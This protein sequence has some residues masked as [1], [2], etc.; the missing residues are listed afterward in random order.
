M[1][2]SLAPTKP[3][4]CSSWTLSLE[5]GWV[6]GAN[7]VHRLLFPFMCVCVFFRTFFMQIIYWICVVHSWI[8]VHSCWQTHEWRRKGRKV[9]K[10]FLL[11]WDIYIC[12]QTEI[13]SL[14]LHHCKYF[15]FHGFVVHSRTCQPFMRC[16]WEGLP[17]L[18]PD[19]TTSKSQ[20]CEDTER[21]G[22]FLS[23]TRTS[24]ITLHTFRVCI[25]QTPHLI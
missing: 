24:P 9:G 1:L 12:S 19:E 7:T 13:K 11:R 10:F 3:V 6:S 25:K 4:S 21:G 16:V 2:S 18:Y 17:E 20:W 5:L 15:P 8:S 22:H 14:K 23:M